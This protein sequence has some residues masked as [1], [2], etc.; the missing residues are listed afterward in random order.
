LGNFEP[1]SFSLR[2]N[3]RTASQTDMA[4]SSDA[5]QKYTHFMGSE[6]SPSLRYKL[7]TEIIVPSARV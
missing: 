3:A 6:T 4:R 7:L 5:D 1:D 2:R